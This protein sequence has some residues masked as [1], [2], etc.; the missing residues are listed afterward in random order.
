[1]IANLLIIQSDIYV[2]TSKEVEEIAFFEVQRLQLTNNF[3][4]EEE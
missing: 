4:T 3:D 1:V 2:I